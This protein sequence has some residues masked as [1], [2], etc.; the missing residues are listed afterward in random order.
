MSNLVAFHLNLHC[1]PKYPFRGL[2]I[3]RVILCFNQVMTR[4]NKKMSSKR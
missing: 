4:D 3:Q 1:L 2:S